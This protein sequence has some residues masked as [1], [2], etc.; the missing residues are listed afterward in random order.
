MAGLKL[1]EF[2]TDEML[3]I[4]EFFRTCKGNAAVLDLAGKFLEAC[5]LYGESSHFHI[6]DSESSRN[7]IIR[8]GEEIP[9][10][11]VVFEA[12]MAWNPKKGKFPAV[13]SGFLKRV[14][15]VPVNMTHYL[16]D[17]ENKIYS[18]LKKHLAAKYPDKSLDALL[19]NAIMNQTDD[20]IEVT[21]AQYG[22]RHIPSFYMEKAAEFAKD[23]TQAFEVDIER[24]Q[25]DEDESDFEISAGL[26][27]RRDTST[28]FEE[29]PEEKIS[30]GAMTHYEMVE[31]AVNDFI[32]TG[33]FN[34]D[35][36]DSVLLCHVVDN[37][38]GS[39]PLEQAL[40]DLATKYT[41]VARIQPV[42][43]HFTKEHGRLPKE[44]E[45]ASIFGIGKSGLTARKVKFASS[46][47]EYLE[48]EG[49]FW[50][51]R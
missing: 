38:K 45:I 8:S 10:H 4:Q 47:A 31:A 22:T 23:Y 14:T 28:S 24:T 44:M 15:I 41:F 37:L 9:Y 3:K 5:T 33:Q 12:V 32:R 51:N 6:S 2:S 39:E 20:L 43:L 27:S 25:D 40:G 36:L 29:S 42:L 11:E 16:L 19:A 1:D 17:R 26:K 34:A 7:K 18:A 21:K 35:Y 48:T 46:L 13:L 30:G 49:L 50:K